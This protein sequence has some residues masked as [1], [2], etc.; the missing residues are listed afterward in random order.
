[1]SWQCPECGTRN[2]DS[3]PNCLDCGCHHEEVSDPGRDAAAAPARPAAGRWVIACPDCLKEITVEGED[4]HRDY[5][6]NC[7]GTSIESKRAYFKEEEQPVPADQPSARRPRLLIQEI[8]AELEASSKFIYRQKG[9]T[10]RPKSDK[11]EIIPPEMEFGRHLLPEWGDYYRT[12]SEKHCKFRCDEK[13]DWFVSDTESKNGTWVNQ[14]FLIG[15]EK[16]RLTKDSE[17]QMADRLFLVF[18]E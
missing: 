1:M 3:Y 17:I 2:A 12:I 7:G 6:D 18:I 14:R 10:P 9:R 5:C 4:A 16:R 15:K 11:I 13:G 8:Q